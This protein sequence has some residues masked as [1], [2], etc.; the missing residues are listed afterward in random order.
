MAAS[1][2]NVHLVQVKDAFTDCQWY[3]SGYAANIRIR[4]ETVSTFVHDYRPRKVLDVGCGDGSLSLP[5]LQQG[6]HVTFLDISTKMLQTVRDRLPAEQKEQASF[7]NLSFDEA[8]FEGASFD[9]IIFVGVLA[10]IQNIDATFAKLRSLL[11][12]GGA[13]ILEYTDASHFIGRLNFGY[14]DV[15]ALFR[16][17]RC[18]TFRHSQAVVDT[19]L[20]R[21][22]FE[23][24]AGFRYFYSIPLLFRYASQMRIYGIIR[25]LFGSAEKPRRQC[26]GSEALGLYQR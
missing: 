3:L 24:K 8:A 11:K 13:L 20:E 23:R 17:P 21:A 5:L 22:G 6:A 12:P 9:A 7:I 10:Y 15:T 19:A 16:L 18:K 4:A 25:T 26:L 14:R 2:D 1:I